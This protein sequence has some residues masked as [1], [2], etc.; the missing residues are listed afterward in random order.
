LSSPFYNHLAAPSDQFASI[1]WFALF[2][3]VLLALSLPTR[4][5]RSAQA[6]SLASFAHLARPLIIFIAAVAMPFHRVKRAPRL[7]CNTPGFAD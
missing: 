6:V 3:G 4:L 7:L 1:S 5:S 2:Q